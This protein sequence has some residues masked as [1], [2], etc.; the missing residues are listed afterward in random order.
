MICPVCKSQALEVCRD[1]QT[2]LEVDSCPQ[3][4]G[5][6]FDGGELETFYQSPELVKRFTPIGGAAL[7]HTYEISSTARRC[8][9]CRKGMERPLVGGIDID[10]CRECR[11]I[12]FDYGELQ[13]VTQIYK[14][15]GL[16]GDDMVAQ[17]V[18]KGVAGPRKEGSKVEDA[19][20]VVSWFFNSF[21]SAK[22][23]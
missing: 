7:H 22:I 10:V 11:G 17:Q 3:C 20:S 19:F 16:K 18:R 4:L 8:P 6:W 15:R 13:K 12:W 1:S 5:V 14:T 2:Q 23:R 9:R 21:L